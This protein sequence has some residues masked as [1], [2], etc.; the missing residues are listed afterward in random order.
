M[1]DDSKPDDSK[2]IPK[3]VNPE[4]NK[5]F[6][7][8]EHFQ[9]IADK[10]QVEI[11]ELKKQLAEKEKSISD[12]DKL[13]SEIEEMKTADEKKRIETEYPDIEPDLIL[14]KSPEEQ[15]DIVDRQRKRFEKFRTESI[16]INAPQNQDTNIDQLIDEISKSNKTP[17]QKSAEISKLQRQARENS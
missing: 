15:K 17:L 4:D 12:V 2:D 9:A 8:V 10:K 16:D 3:G 1:N 14:G 6:K 11:E 13:K 7:G 5:D